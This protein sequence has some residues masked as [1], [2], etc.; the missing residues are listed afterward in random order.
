MP[1]DTQSILYSLDTN[2]FEDLAWGGFRGS[3]VWTIYP[4]TIGVPAGR[5]RGRYATFESMKKVQDRYWKKGIPLGMELELEIPTQDYLRDYEPVREVMLLINKRVQDGMKNFAIRQGE[6]LFRY[7]TPV[8]A[9]GDGSLR[10]GVEFNFQPMTRTA[11]TKY[12]AYAFEDIGYDKF[13]GF[14][15]NSAGIHIHMPKSAFSDPELF[16]YIM[17]WDTMLTAKT[18]NGKTFSEVMGQRAFNNYCAGRPARWDGSTRAQEIISAVRERSSRT[19]KFNAF[20]YAGHGNTIEI[21]SFKSNQDPRR[22][23]KNMAFVDMSWRYVHLL[24]DFANDGRYDKL[25]QFLSDI[26]MFAMYLQ[27][28]TMK[29]YNEHLARFVRASWRRGRVN[30]PNTFDA[31]VKNAFIACNEEFQSRD[32]EQ[33]NQDTTEEVTS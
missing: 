23:I 27:N 10:N 22:L 5:R 18:R 9:K 26:D 33:T 21:R 3:D 30:G 4:N 31:S 11:F 28:P 7:V 19:G 15:T 14:R 12:V 24:M 13:E 1:R 17:L 8:T 16:M 29:G 2:P 20:N 32:W 6:D 25:W